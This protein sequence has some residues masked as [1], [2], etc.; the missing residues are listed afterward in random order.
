[1]HDIFSDPRFKPISMMEMYDRLR[2]AGIFPKNDTKLKNA[3]I[4]IIDSFPSDLIYREDD[5]RDNK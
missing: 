2:K 3:S 5:S 1:M 4:I